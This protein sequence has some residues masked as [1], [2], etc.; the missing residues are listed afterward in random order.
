MGCE[1]TFHLNGKAISYISK[2]NRSDELTLNK[3]TEELLSDHRMKFSINGKEQEG[4]FMVALQSLLKKDAKTSEAFRKQLSKFIEGHNEE[5]LVGNYTIKD[6]AIKYPKLN[7]E[8]LEDYLEDDEEII[9]RPGLKYNGV[10]LGGV[11]TINDRT[12]HILSNYYDVK[13]FIY[14][15]NL[16]KKLS[17]LESDSEKLGKYINKNA[18]LRQSIT[19]IK[20]KEN[21]KKDLT[22][23]QYFFKHSDKYLY[24]MTEDNVDIYATISNCLKDLFYDQIQKKELSHPLANSIY[25]RATLNKKFQ[26]VLSLE[27]VYELCKNINDEIS[28]KILEI[29]K[30]KDI[31]DDDKI[32]RIRLEISELFNKEDLPLSVSIHNSNLYFSKPYVSFEDFDYTERQLNIALKVFSKFG[33]NCFEFQQKGKSE[34]FVS[35]DNILTLDSYAGNKFDTLEEA[36][37]YID[38]KLKHQSVFKGFQMEKYHLNPGQNLHFKAVTQYFNPKKHSSFDVYK[39]NISNEGTIFDQVKEEYRKYLNYNIQDAIRLLS[40]E[41]GFDLSS[42]ITDYDKFVILLL[43]LSKGST[44]AQ[45]TNRI[46]Q[47]GFNRYFV[48]N[49]ESLG[50]G[51]YNLKLSEITPGITSNEGD[52]SANLPAPTIVY[53]NNLAEM[54]NQKFKVNNNTDQNIIEIISNDDLTEDMPKGVKGFIQ[55]GVIKINAS[56]AGL[57]DLAHEFSHLFLGMLKAYDID[58]YIQLLQKVE[59]DIKIITLK[60]KLKQ[61]EN[62]KQLSDTDLTEEAFVRLFSKDILHNTRKLSILENEINNKFE[63]AVEEFKTNLTTVNTLSDLFKSFNTVLITSLSQGNGLELDSMAAKQRQAVNIMKD[64]LERKE[65]IEN[66]I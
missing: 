39:Y 24:S 5:S 61:N 52:E 9:Y 27:D 41:I 3:I 19:F 25:Q 11:V 45:A 20:Q 35:N 43:E 32:E 62:Y 22:A 14:N 36:K 21:I 31:N 63:E 7:F 1:V 46:N 38:N 48:V 37:K 49:K 17:E 50:N 30:S 54:I 60:A 44:P 64:K 2:Y 66:C 42:T 8:G 47:L 55:N 34:F 16:R 13:A 26:Y 12:Y 4:N 56:K 18:A 33:L 6:L 28:T 58:S 51:K 15:L 65:I 57:D 53:L 29:Q 23:L 59:S 10:G 40:K